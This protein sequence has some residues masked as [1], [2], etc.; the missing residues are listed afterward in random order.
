MMANAKQLFI[1]V[2]LTFTSLKSL[3]QFV[4]SY[5]GYICLQIECM[6][7]FPLTNNEN[8]RNSSM[9]CNS[10]SFQVYL[11]V[12]HRFIVIFVFIA[13]IMFKLMLFKFRQNYFIT[14][15]L[16]CQNL[17]VSNNEIFV[18]CFSCDPLRRSISFYSSLNVSFS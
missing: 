6:A 18:S 5:L 10:S 16:S 4:A 12:H 14:K 11:Q 3:L 17:F 1:F 9:A 8:F 13:I 15:W 7:L 2:K